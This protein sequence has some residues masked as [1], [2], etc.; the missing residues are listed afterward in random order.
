MRR[1]AEILEAVMG[2]FLQDQERIRIAVMS[3]RLLLL[4]LFVMG[5][6]ALSGCAGSVKL[7]RNQSVSEPQLASA[8]F[9]ASDGRVIP[10][11]RFL[12][13]D[14]DVRAIVVALHGFNDYSRAFTQVGAYLAEQG[15][16]LIAYDQ[17]GFGLS[18]NTGLWAGP[19]AYAE[20]L[21]SII[22]AVKARYR[23]LP[24][25]LLGESMGAAVA[26]SALG[27]DPA[28]PVNGV[29]LSAPAV[30]SRDTMPW[31]QSMIL[32]LAAVTMPEMRLTGSGLRV[33]ASDNLEMLRGLGRDPWVIKATRVDAIKGLADLM[34][35]AQKGVAQVKVPVLI[36]Y[37][38]KDEIIP[39]IPV[40]RLWKQV[41]G[42][43]EVRAAYYPGGYHLL[44]RDLEASIPLRDVVGWILDRKAPLASG[45]EL[46]APQ[47]FKESAVFQVGE[48]CL[49]GR[50]VSKHLGVRPG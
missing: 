7:E 4:G 3:C 14:G 15:I 48:A 6:F 34:D 21:Q 44:L 23:G 31:Y 9:L 45:C 20:D 41:E 42:K 24:I 19:S 17:R 40:E 38:G 18:E 8:H 47:R 26:I 35:E 43:P 12:P 46:R 30:W 49:S 1:F 28:L 29:I 36:L 11:R 13:A 5:F 32:D 50:G 37:G 25:F 22:K 2:V 33:Q 39:S 16:G 27:N 10:V